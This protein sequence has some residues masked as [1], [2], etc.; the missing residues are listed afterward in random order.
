MKTSPERIQELIEEAIIDAYDEE[1][2][3]MGFFNMIEENVKTPFKAKVIGE[4][5]EVVE[6]TM[7]ETNEFLAVCKRNGKK[8]TVNLT[9]LKFCDPLPAGYEWIEAFLEW[10]KNDW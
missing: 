4:E 7:G 9:S 1:E 8:H 2:Q 3:F 6:I 5:V 10:K